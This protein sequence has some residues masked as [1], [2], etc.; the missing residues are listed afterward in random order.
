[1]FH[2]HTQLRGTDFFVTGSLKNTSQHGHVVILDMIE[3]YTAYTNTAAK[4][5]NKKVGQ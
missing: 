1:M 2:H 3:L 5:E 4:N